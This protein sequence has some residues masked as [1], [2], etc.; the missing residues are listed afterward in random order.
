MIDVLDIKSDNILINGK[1]EVKLADFGFAVR[2]QSSVGSFI[3]HDD[4]QNERRK[5]VVGTPFWMAPELIKGGGYTS[6]VDIW[7]LGITAL[8]MA[9]GEP[10]YF[11]LPPLKALMLIHTQPP[12]K[13]IEPSKWSDDFIDFLEKA[14][15]LDVLSLL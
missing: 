3:F 4:Y 9:N 8:E 10:P 11:H 14:L 15:R 1:G 13:V 7:S 5:S 2:L 12:P 6:K